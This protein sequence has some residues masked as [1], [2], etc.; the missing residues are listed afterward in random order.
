[1]D[2][3]IHNT[4][5]L[6]CDED[7]AF[8]MFTINKNL[9]SW[10]TLQADVEPKAGGK[11]ELFWD[12]NDRENDSTIGCKITAIEPGKFLSFEW[13]GPQQFAHFLDILG[14]KDTDINW[15]GKW[16]PQR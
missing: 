5:Q 14:L 4:I 10:L 3:I 12:P 13:K 15:T 8:K 7:Q 16:H 11:Y 6:N 9:E 1:M 2:K